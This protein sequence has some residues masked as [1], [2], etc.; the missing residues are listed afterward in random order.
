MFNDMTPEE[1]AAYQQY[2]Q[3]VLDRIKHRY[4]QMCRLGPASCRRDSVALL[5]LVSCA[6]LWLLSDV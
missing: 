6:K 2:A 3:E 1:Q 5:V 4:I